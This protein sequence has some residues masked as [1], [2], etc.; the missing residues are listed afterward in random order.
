MRKIYYSETSQVNKTPSKGNQGKY[1]IN[2][3]W[4]KTDYLGYES[5][6]EYLASELLAESNIDKFVPYTLEK[7]EIENKHKFFR[8]ETACISKNFLPDG[9][10]IVTLDKLFKQQLNTTFENEVKGKEIKESIKHV[11]SL[12]EQITGIKEYGN[13]LTKMLEF[14]ALVLNEDRHVQNIAFIYQDGKYTPC[15]IFD[16]GASF[17]SDISQD[18]PLEEKTNKLISFVSSKPFSSSFSKQVKACHELYGRQLEIKIPDI[19]KQISVIKSFYGDKIASR[20]QHIYNIQ[21]NKNKDILNLI[22]IPKEQ[23]YQ[24]PG[25]P[26]FTEDGMLQ[27]LKDHLSNG[28]HIIAAKIP[29]EF[30]EKLKEKLVDEEIPYAVSKDED[31]TPLVFTKDILQKDFL[32]VQKIVFDTHKKNP[33]I[34]PTFQKIEEATLQI[35]DYDDI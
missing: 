7:V 3:E 2:D 1:H 34:K 22:T 27:D 10:E 16:N 30:L 11:V 29:N 14:D 8:K 4:I 20:I 35:G 33:E 13:H 5:A 6:S 31:G 32:K 25:T 12:I 28:G 26:L 23:E 18:Y 24:E 9:A 21:V 19:T 17:L 15:P